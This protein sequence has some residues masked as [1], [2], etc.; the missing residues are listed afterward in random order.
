MKKKVIIGVIAVAVIAAIV[1]LILVLTHK[2]KDEYRVVKV[3]NSAGS[4]S[5]DRN[6]ESDKLEAFQGM[7]LVS[8]DKVEV[9]DSS[10]LELLLDTDKHVIAEANTKFMLIATGTAKAGTVRIKITE[11]SSLFEIDNKLNDESSFEVS[12]PNA[13]FSVRGTKFRVTYDKDKNETTLEVLEG[14]VAID[15][16]NG[17]DEEEVEAGKGRIITDSDSTEIDVDVDAVD[18]NGGADDTTEDASNDTTEDNANGGTVDNGGSD[19]TY[20][21]ITNQSDAVAAY[22]AIIKDMANYLAMYSNKGH[23]Y[24]AFDYMY[25]DY[26][27]DGMNELILYPEYKDA[28]GEFYRDVAFVDYNVDSQSIVCVGINYAEH[29]DTHFYA[30]YNGMLCR[31]SWPKNKVDESYLYYVAI[32]DQGSIIYVLEKSYDYLVTDLDA[33]GLHPI[34]LHGDWEMIFED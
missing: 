31:Y 4:V 26:D 13:V 23:D 21:G 29:N 1:T 25:F 12:T 28:D 24:V 2:K 8:G 22:N 30:E 20:T 7:K 27:M 33:E 34:P 5:V 17:M 18:N 32:N 3:E 15:Y 6:S 19:D 14:V 9:G 16:A 10:T 11:G